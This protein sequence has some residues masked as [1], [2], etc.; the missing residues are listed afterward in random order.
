MV[1]TVQDTR[2][3]VEK[4][5]FLTT[6]GWI[7]GGD[8]RYEAGLP[9]GTGPYRIIT[10]MAVMDFEPGSRRMRIL[11]INPGYSMKDVRDNCGFELKEAPKITE[12]MAPTD[13]ELSILREEVDPY[14]Y[15]IGR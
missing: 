13:R 6:P 9:L 12:T 8:S 1:M 15:I 10:N 14:R 5:D 3:F 11:S 2:R 7:N 4:V